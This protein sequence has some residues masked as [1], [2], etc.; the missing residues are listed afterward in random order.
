M[1]NN[2]TLDTALQW[3]ICCAPALTALIRWRRSESPPAYQQ[4]LAWGITVGVVVAAT[5][6]PYT[7]VGEVP[8]TAL[9]VVAAAAVAWGWPVPRG[10]WRTPWLAMSVAV[11]GAALLAWTGAT[12]FALSDRK[13]FRAFRAPCGVDVRA[14]DT[15]FLRPEAKVKTFERVAFVLE[16]EVV[17]EHTRLDVDDLVL[18]AGEGC[19]FTLRSGR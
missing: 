17:S 14:Y 16:R 3:A 18:E 13:P 6:T 5:A 9:K 15:T 8:D 7:F 11:G 4:R 1:I 10:R 2:P 12:A 19:T